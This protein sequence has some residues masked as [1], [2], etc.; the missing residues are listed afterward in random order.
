MNT[1]E[2]IIRLGTNQRVPHTHI[3][4]RN[5]AVTKRQYESLSG[6]PDNVTIW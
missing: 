4:E 1:Q 6:I 3:V 5:I 2:E